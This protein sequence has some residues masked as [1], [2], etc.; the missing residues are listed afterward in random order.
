MAAI[1]KNFKVLRVNESC[2]SLL[3]YLWEKKN[4][5]T[6][7]HCINVWK[8]TSQCADK[9]ST[10]VALGWEDHEALRRTQRRALLSLCFCV[11]TW[12][13][14]HPREDMPLAAAQTQGQVAGS[15]V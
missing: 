5:I 10:A 11:P 7:L 8:N 1:W 3:L 13:S 12:Q 14:T 9:E 4:K 2:P 15:G 6:W